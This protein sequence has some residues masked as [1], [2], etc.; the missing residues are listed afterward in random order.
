MALFDQKISLAELLSLIPDG[1]IERI[2]VETRVDYCTKRLGGKLMLN[3]LLYAHLSRERL[4]LRGLSDVLTS[5][6]FKLLFDY[7]HHQ[8]IAHSSLSDRLSVID[9]DFFRLSYQRIRERFCQSFCGETICGLQVQRVDSTLVSEAAGKLQ[10]GMTCGNNYKRKKM[11]KY[12]LNYDG[13]SGSCCCVHT[14]EKYASESLALPQNVFKHFK[15]EKNHSHVYIFDR[16]QSAAKAFDDLNSHQ[17]LLF[18]GRLA[19]NRKLSVVKDFDLTY[20]NFTHGQ[21]KQDALVHLYDKAKVKTDG[22]YRVIRFRPQGKDQDILLITNIF[23]LR[24]ETIAQ[25]YRRRW[26]IEVFFRFLKQ[27]LNFSHFLSLNTN[28]IEVVMYTIL[29]AA[30]L[31]MIYKK[32]NQLGYK[33]AIRKMN[34]ELQKIMIVMVVKITGGDIRKLDKYNLNLPN[35]A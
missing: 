10:T 2:A 22:I 18:V 11:V 24:A 3:M 15:R 30:M 35:D 25:M 31:V 17:G 29:I 5:A 1:E 28:G 4:G 19:D 14:A 27:E 26:D 6:D 13:M 20:R 16:G 23:H 7:G 8:G 34:T 9:V 12:T 33:T 32:E 21:L